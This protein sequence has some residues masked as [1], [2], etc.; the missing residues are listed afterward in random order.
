MII[1]PHMTADEQQL[2]ENGHS[3]KYRGF[4]IQ[5]KRDFGDN[6]FWSSEHRCKVN[7]GWV[8][9]DGGIVNVVPGAMWA[10][11]IE[12]TKEIIDDLI[13]VGGEGNATEFWNRRRRLNRNVT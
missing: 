9:T 7:A 6:G 12:Q 10:W 8:I 5:P 13:A 2:Y 11:T 3:E 4:T 1:A